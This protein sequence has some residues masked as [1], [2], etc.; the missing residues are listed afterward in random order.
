MK[1]L[2]LVS[3]GRGGS[4]FFQGLLD[5]HNEILQIPEKLRIN[6]QFLEI[7]NSQNNKEIA[8]KFIRFVPLIFDSRKNKLER[9]DKLGPRRNQHYIVNKKKFC[10]YFE[11]LSKKKFSKKFRLLRICIKHIT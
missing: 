8:E 7:F 5:N 1:V 11:K 3:G 9:H 4:D 6:K 10:Y 2:V